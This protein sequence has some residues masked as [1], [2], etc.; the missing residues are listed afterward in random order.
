V[1]TG[2]EYRWDGRYLG[3][4]AFLGIPWYVMVQGS[5]LGWES[6]SW[7]VNADEIVPIM[8]FVLTSSFV[9]FLFR[10]WIR[11][12]RRFGLLFSGTCLMCAGALSCS[13]LVAVGECAVDLL[14]GSRDIHLVEALYMFPLAIYSVSYIGI[15]FAIEVYY[16][17]IPMGIASVALLRWVDRTTSGG[18]G[19]S[20][21][22]GTAA[23]STRAL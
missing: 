18:T 6:T 13:T 7:R 4:A 3:I 23:T 20:T 17:T 15:G 8:A 12:T 11:R 5:T 9:A 14:R 22:H 19:A 16:L 21:R 1:N 10:P 2:G